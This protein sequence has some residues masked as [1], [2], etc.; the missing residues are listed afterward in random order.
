MLELLEDDEDA[1]EHDEEV[2]PVEKEWLEQGGDWQE[3][4]I[5]QVKENIENL[6]FQLEA[7]KLIKTSKTRFERIDC[8]AHV[9]D[10]RKFTL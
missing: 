2:L 1:D 10:L 3:N 4:E 5:A 6:E 8:T 9:A 7:Q